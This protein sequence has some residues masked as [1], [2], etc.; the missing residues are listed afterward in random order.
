MHCIYIV[1]YPVCTTPQLAFTP[2]HTFIEFIHSY[3][4]PPAQRKLTF[5]HCAIGNNL[6]RVKY[7]SFP[8][9]HLQHVDNTVGMMTAGAGNESSTFLDDL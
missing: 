7:I 4:M 8:R 5:T 2:S 1:L 3:K 9:T 6:G